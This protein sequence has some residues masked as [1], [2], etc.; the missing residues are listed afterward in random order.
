[1]APD[2]DR[3]TGQGPTPHHA[4]E[5]PFRPRV[6]HPA[7]PAEEPVPSSGYVLVINDGKLQAI[8]TRLVGGLRDGRADLWF[9]PG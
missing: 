2:R 6:V 8:R 9:T 5:R 7:G 1:M 3:S 4:G